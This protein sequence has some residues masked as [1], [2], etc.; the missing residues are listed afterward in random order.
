MNFHTFILV[1][2]GVCVSVWGG[3]YSASTLK[4]LSDCCADVNSPVSV[5]LL[6]VTGE[7]QT[8]PHVH[9]CELI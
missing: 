4:T 5:F 8:F 1:C 2:V 6:Q 3:R 9:V 7:C